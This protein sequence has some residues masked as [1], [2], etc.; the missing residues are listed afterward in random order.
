VEALPKQ[1]F[2]FLIGF[3]RP[4]VERRGSGDGARDVWRPPFS[5]D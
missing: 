4:T 1:G 2:H 5:D 3:S